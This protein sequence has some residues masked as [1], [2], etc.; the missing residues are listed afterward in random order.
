M[1]NRLEDVVGEITVD[2][3][4][5][6][7][8]YWI[9]VVPFTLNIGISVLLRTTY[10]SNVETLYSLENITYNSFIAGIF[11]A[12]ILKK[13]YDILT[14]AFVSSAGFFTGLNLANYLLKGG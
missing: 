7:L 14:M 6:N 12:L 3:K 10:F 4:S 2:N 1:D 8:K 5:S 9:Y 11:N 13:Q